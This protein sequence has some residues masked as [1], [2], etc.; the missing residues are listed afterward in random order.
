[1]GQP[2]L[3]LAALEDMVS[4]SVKSQR[5]RQVFRHRKTGISRPGSLSCST[6]HCMDMFCPT[7][8]LPCAQKMMPKFWLLP[9]L[10]SKQIYVFKLCIFIIYHHLKNKALVCKQNKVSGLSEVLAACWTIITKSRNCWLC[11]RKKSLCDD[12]R[13]HCSTVDMLDGGWVKQNGGEMDGLYYI[14]LR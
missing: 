6:A 11:S 2:R 9:V 3:P 10:L 4:V 14:V 12:S 5:G 7:I 13:K 8:L 1:M